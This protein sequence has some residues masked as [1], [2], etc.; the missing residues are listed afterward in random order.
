MGWL[1]RWRVIGL[2]KASL[3][4][5]ILDF[6]MDNCKEGRCGKQAM[7]KTEV[8]KQRQIRNCPHRP[9]RGG[10]SSEYDETVVIT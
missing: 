2:G 6:I 7:E 5:C 8:Q 1:Q 10:K 4:S 3:A 9:Q